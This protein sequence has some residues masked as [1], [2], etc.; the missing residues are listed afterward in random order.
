[1]SETEVRLDFARPE[2]VGFDE[3]ILCARKTHY[4]LTT[5]MDSR[6]WKKRRVR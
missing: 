2:R 5:I 3:A 4:Q 6:F 1:M